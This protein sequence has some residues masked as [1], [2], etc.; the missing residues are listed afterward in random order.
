[1]IIDVAKII[2]ALGYVVYAALW[3]PV[4]VI[5]LLVLPVVWLV[6]FMRGGMTMKEAIKLYGVALKA[7]FMHDVNFIK[8]G[9]W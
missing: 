4:I 3:S 7:S 9:V 5:L 2:R 6:T 1:M 8:T